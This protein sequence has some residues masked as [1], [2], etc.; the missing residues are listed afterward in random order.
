MRRPT[1]TDVHIS[2]TTC[3]HPIFPSGVLCGKPCMTDAQHGWLCPM[4]EA[5]V[6]PHKQAEARIEEV[7]V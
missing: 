2:K 1:F 4:H 6:V 3:I 5:L 7:K